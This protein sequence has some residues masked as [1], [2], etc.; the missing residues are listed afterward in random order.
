MDIERFEINEFR[1]QSRIGLQQNKK[2]HL[3]QSVSTT[4]HRKFHGKVDI[5][6]DN[7]TSYQVNK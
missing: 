5:K 6:K 4:I 1:R 3:Q 7:V 2:P